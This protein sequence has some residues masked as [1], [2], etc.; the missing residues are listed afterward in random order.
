M[1]ENGAETRNETVKVSG[2]DLSIVRGGTGRP[3]L[4]LHDELGY[5]GWMN[6]NQALARNHSQ[7]I[8]MHPGFGVT[9]EPHWI[10]NVRDLAGFYSIF[11]NDQ[12]LVPIDVIGFSIGG[13]IA[14][15]MAAANPGQFRRMILVAPDGIKPSLGEITDMFQL[16]APDQLQASV[17]DPTDTP[18]FGTL[19]GGM[20]PEAFELMEQARAQTARLAWQ[21]FMYNPSL[22]FLLAIVT[23]LPTLIIW[24]EQD[25]MVPVAAAEDYRR[26]IRG[27][28]VVKFDRCGH[29]PE[30]EKAAEFIRETETFLA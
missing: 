20:R 10:R 14:A 26:A 8:P 25:R 5:P 22:A 16:M 15:E 18:E 3:L 11:L 27:A 12:K 13:W 4:V 28:K 17:L 23:S 30:I 6:W 21:P 29:R 7:I 24:G 9:P 1:A 2:T 19:Y